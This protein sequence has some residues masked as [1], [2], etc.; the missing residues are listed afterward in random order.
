MNNQI[1]AVSLA[2]ACFTLAAVFLCS[3]NTALAATPASPAQ[4]QQG[5]GRDVANI[6]AQAKAG[7]ANAQYKLAILFAQGDGV[8]RDRQQVLFWNRKAAEQGHAD[9]QFGMGGMYFVGDGVATDRQQAMDWF[10]RAAEQGQVT[11]QYTLGALHF[12]DMM[13]KSAAQGDGLLK[14]AMAKIEKEKQA[15]VAGTK[16]TVPVKPEV[17]DNKAANKEADK[18]A[19]LRADINKDK[20]L[21]FLWLT[22]AARHGYQD[23]GNLLSKLKWQLTDEEKRQFTAEVDAWKPHQ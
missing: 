12:G 17:V 3:G 15:A 21:A 11:A 19:E 13:D 10:R 8:A 5:D 6:M 9:A 1:R 14:N 18:E 22:L 7:D 20:R 23:S 2:S 16:E 4:Q